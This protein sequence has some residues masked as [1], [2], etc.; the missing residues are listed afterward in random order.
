MDTDEILPM[1]PPFHPLLV[2]LASGK[3]KKQRKVGE[4]GISR[5]ASEADDEEEDDND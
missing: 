5:A 3:G 2:K 1:D 4:A